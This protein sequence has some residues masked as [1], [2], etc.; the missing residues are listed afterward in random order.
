MRTHTRIYGLLLCLC[1][2]AAQVFSSCIREDLSECGVLVKFRYTHNMLGADAFCQ[3]ADWVRLWIFDS[4]KRLV[5]EYMEDVTQVENGDFS[6]RIPFLSAGDYTFVAWAGSNDF[7]GAPAYFEFPD[8]QPGDPMTELTA[9]L[10]RTDEGHHC[11]PLNSLLN[12]KADTGITGELQTV[13]MKMMKCTKDIRIIL[14]PLQDDREM[15]AEDFLLHIEDINGTLAHDASIFG[16]D[17]VIYRAWRKEVSVSPDSSSKAFTINS[18]MIADMSTSR[19]VQE[20]EPRMIITDTESGNRVMD[21]DLT[22]ILTLQAIGERHQNWSDQE[23]LDRQD[24]Y[25]V[26]F[27]IDMDTRTWAQTRIIINGWVIS[28]EEIEL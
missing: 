13:T 19:L 12:G 28:L 21:I 15:T 18:A 5:C 27:F 2:A 11:Y 22:W 3:E 14:M 20:N 7:E 26:T 25:S 17:S 9:R 24:T 4:H 23:Y 10:P 6:I 1:A 16:T 8:L